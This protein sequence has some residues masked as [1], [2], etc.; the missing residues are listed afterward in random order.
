MVIL[1][2]Y[3]II[4]KWSTNKHIIHTQHKHDTSIFVRFNVHDFSTI[5]IVL[6]NIVNPDIFNDDANEIF[7]IET[8]LFHELSSILTNC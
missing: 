3:G 2:G 4:M 7:I 6:L 1:D 8:L 5:Q